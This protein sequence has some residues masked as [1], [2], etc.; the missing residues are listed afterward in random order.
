VGV[1][2]TNEGKLL[3]KKKK[4]LNNMDFLL[5]RILCLYLNSKVSTSIP[6]MNIGQLNVQDV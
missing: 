5:R 2:P 1:I 3:K 6:V 4:N